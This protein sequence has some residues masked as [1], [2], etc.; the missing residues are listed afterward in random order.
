MSDAKPIYTPLTREECEDAGVPFNESD[1]VMRPPAPWGFYLTRSGKTVRPTK[2]QEVPMEEEVSPP[3]APVSDYRVAA[4]KYIKLKRYEKRLEEEIKAVRDELIEA[5]EDGEFVAAADDHG[6]Q[7]Y[8]TLNKYTRE[9]FNSKKMW[10]D[11]PEE[12]R[13]IMA[14]YISRTPV[15]S[16]LIK[17]VEKIE[18]EK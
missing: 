16:V 15:K 14:Q 11:S 7:F 1:P 17:P 2:T 3:V 9:N 5:L 18:K 13:A 6:V 10:E 12:I 8:L 4:A